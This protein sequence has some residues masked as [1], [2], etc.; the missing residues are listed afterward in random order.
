M[1]TINVQFKGIELI[2]SAFW[3]WHREKTG[4]LFNATARPPFTH[5]QGKLS[6]RWIVT[7]I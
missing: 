5:A 4:E 2:L 7:K 3:S 1:V 6:K